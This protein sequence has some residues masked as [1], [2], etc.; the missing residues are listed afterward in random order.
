MPCL[1]YVTDF[2]L[3]CA[4]VCAHMCIYMRVHLYVCASARV[5][6]G[7]RPTLAVFFR[8]SPPELGSVA[9]PGALPFG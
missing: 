8:H 1:L 6:G 4:C 2:A 7:Q 9:E 5:C 3:V